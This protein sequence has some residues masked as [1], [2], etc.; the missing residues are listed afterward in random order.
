MASGY[1]QSTGYFGTLSGNSV[2]VPAFTGTFGPGGYY[3]PQASS[4]A[5]AAALSRYGQPP[6]NF[7]M[8]TDQMAAMQD[9][10]DFYLDNVAKSTLSLDCI[11]SYSDY[12]KRV[13]DMLSKND[14]GQDEDDFIYLRTESEVSINLNIYE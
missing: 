6:S 11:P 12:D 10:R 5:T 7:K 3:E 8:Y 4:R 1:M 14:Y 9:R 13:L 2:T